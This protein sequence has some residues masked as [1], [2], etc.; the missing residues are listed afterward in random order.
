MIDGGA[1]DDTLIG[2]NASSTFTVNAPNA[3]NDPS[4]GAG[5]Q[6]DIEAIGAM[7][8]HPAPVITSLTV[9][10][11]RNATR[12]EPVSTPSGPT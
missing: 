2:A 10:D 8:C 11:T 7:G 5:I 3:G 9:Q 6:A 1:G 4:G 12:I